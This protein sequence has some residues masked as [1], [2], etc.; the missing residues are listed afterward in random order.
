MAYTTRLTFI[1]ITQMGLIM[2]NEMIIPFSEQESVDV[3]PLP[4][5]DEEG[6]LSQI[7]DQNLFSSLLVEV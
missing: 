6:I 2:G 7:I 5:D 4:P 1:L 3:L